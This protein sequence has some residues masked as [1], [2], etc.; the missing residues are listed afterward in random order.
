MKKFISGYHNENEKDFNIPLI[1]GSMDRPLHECT[2]DSLKTME[3]IENISIVDWEYTEDP[4]VVND[5]TPISTRKKKSKS[6]RGKAKEEEDRKKYVPLTDSNN[7]QLSVRFKLTA[8]DGETEITKNFLIP[9][10][11]EDGYL[12]SKGKRFYMMYQLLD[13]STYVHKNNLIQK[14]LMPVSISRNISKHSDIHDFEY[15]AKTYGYQVSQKKEADVLIFYFSKWGMSETFKFFGVQDV[16]W[17]SPK[18]MEMDK[19]TYFKI[20]KGIHLAV[21]KKAMKFPYVMSI[22]FMTLN[23]VSNRLRIEDV[24]N[25]EFWLEKLGLARGGGVKSYNIVDYGR[26]SLEFLERNLN[27]ETK[28][29]LKLDKHNKETSFHLIR[30]MIQNYS[31]LRSKDELSLDNKR[32]RRNE[33]I[34]SLLTKHINSRLHR[35]IYMG[36]KVKLENLLELFNFPS[37][38][39]VSALHRS[40]LMRYDERVNDLDFIS[41]LN[42]TTKGPNSLNE[43]KQKSMG[44]KFRNAHPSYLGNIDLSV[45]SSS[46]PGSS[47]MF[48]PFAKTYGMHFSDKMEPQ[49]GV[50]DFNEFVQEE[51]KGQESKPV[52]RFKAAD[53]VEETEEE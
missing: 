29:V 30:W 15:V 18:P 22:V 11:D 43:K 32:I 21:D 47:G 24:D 51:F 42:Y 39:L 31:A 53:A 34:A 1:T 17:L 45:N 37:N 46:D 35:I 48:T 10:Q 23:L 44:L 3:V 52:V 8:S 27:K 41:K 26:S 25:T 5:T 12:F 6:K 19:Y 40:G 13:A 36:D 4:A 49:E 9:Y 38:Y 14:S 50:D 2:L 16:I 20:N 28:D 33:Y 7:G